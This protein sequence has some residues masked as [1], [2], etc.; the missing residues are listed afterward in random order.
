MADEVKVEIVEDRQIQPAGGDSLI[1][2]AIERG[3]DTDKLEKLMDLRN[4]EIE[5]QAKLAFDDAFAR[6]Q[7]EFGPVVRSKTA[8]G[9]DGKPMYAYAPLEA[10][11][12]AVGAIIAKHGFSYSWNEVNVEGG[13]RVTMTITGHGASRTSTFDVPMVQGTR[14]MSPVQVMG[15][16]STYGRRYTFL[17]GFGIVVQDEDD[18]AQAASINIADDLN[19]IDSAA[20]MEELKAAYI[21]AYKRHDGNRKAQLEIIKAK[22]FRKKE[23]GNAGH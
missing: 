9:D 6:M 8:K 17:A 23:L 12:D 10:L 7:A 20:T 14:R 11:Q 4:K 19:A 1:Q 15:A 22:D 18:D 3:L 16:M 5:R 21:D 13:K 2:L